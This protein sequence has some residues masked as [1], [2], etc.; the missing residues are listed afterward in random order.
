MVG[1]VR[2]ID[3]GM[4]RSVR[5]GIAQGKKAKEARIDAF[6]SRFVEFGTCKMHARPFFRPA[7]YSKQNTIREH[8]LRRLSEVIK[9]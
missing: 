2:L 3:D 9:P 8:I 7:I 4:V 6:Y 1:S 5:V